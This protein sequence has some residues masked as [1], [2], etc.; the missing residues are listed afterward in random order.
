M[1]GRPRR[2]ARMRANPEPLPEGVFWACVWARITHPH[3]MGTLAQRRLASIE[4]H[5]NVRHLRALR[6][7]AGEWLPIGGRL[8]WARPYTDHANGRHMLEMAQSAQAAMEKMLGQNRFPSE[9]VAGEW[10][11]SNAMFFDLQGLALD[12]QLRHELGL[13]P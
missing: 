8:L 13:P 6:I 2:R 7:S 4:M 11:A 1:A 12:E 3:I 10:L 5:A 9:S